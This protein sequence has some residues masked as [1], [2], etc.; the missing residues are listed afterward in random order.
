MQPLAMVQSRLDSVTND[1][2]DMIIEGFNFNPHE[3]GVFDSA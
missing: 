3:T 2:L 1:Q